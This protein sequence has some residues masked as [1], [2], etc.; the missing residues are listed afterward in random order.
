MYLGSI[1]SEFLVNV[2]SA[3]GEFKASGGSGNTSTS[4]PVPLARIG[5]PH[6]ESVLIVCGSQAEWL[7][8]GETRFFE[9]VRDTLLSYCWIVIILASRTQK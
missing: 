4:A 2:C 1:G 7:R 5:C 6:R 9:T 8:T 3:M